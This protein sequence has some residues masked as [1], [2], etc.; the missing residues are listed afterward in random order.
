LKEALTEKEHRGTLA[1][2]G[3]VLFL[4]LDAG[5]MATLSL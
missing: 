1:D 4:N 3:N 2:A 5:Y